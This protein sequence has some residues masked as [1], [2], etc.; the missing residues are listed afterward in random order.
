MITLTSVYRE[1]GA[2]TI[3]YHLLQERTPEMS[4]SHKAMPT[5][6]EHAKF[7]ASIPYQ[8]WYI[9][10]ANYAPAPVGAIYLTRAREVGIFI[11][12]AHQGKG[13]AHAALAELRKLH[14]GRMLANIS[15]ENA[16]S[17]KFFE[18][19]GA[20]LIQYTYELP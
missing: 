8:G 17:I 19:H 10:R 4:I 14:P 9:V 15:P 7:M 5:I 2:A 20:R 12:K 13:Y 18:K 3:L 16:R 1:P 6:M 11:F